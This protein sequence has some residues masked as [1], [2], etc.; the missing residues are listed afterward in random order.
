MNISDGTSQLSRSYYLN[1]DNF[2]HIDEMSFHEL[3]CYAKKLAKNIRYF[4]LDNQPEGNWDELLNSDEITVISEIIVVDTK[5]IETEFVEN[6][7]SDFGDPDEYL[8][9]QIDL[10]LKL[11]E[12]V[13]SWYVQ[14]S[15]IDAYYTGGLIKTIAELIREKLC[16][17][18]QD[19]RDLQEMLDNQNQNTNEVNKF[20]KFHKIW[21]LD[22]AEKSNEAG[23]RSLKKINIVLDKA[24]YT[25]YNSINYLKTIVPDYFE[26]SL[27]SQTHSP[28]LSLFFTFIKLYLKVRDRLNSFPEKFFRFYYNDI[29]KIKPRE[30]IPDS[31]YLVFTLKDGIKD[32]YIPKG[33]RFVGGKDETKKAIYY[34]SDNDIVINKARIAKLHTLYLEKNELIW[35]KCDCTNLFIDDI[36]VLDPDN[37]KGDSSKKWA[38]FGGSLNE[39]GK[40]G[41]LGFV[42]SD[43]N[44]LLTEGSRAI[45]LEIYFTQ[46]SFQLFSKKLNKIKD[47]YSV[48]EVF[49]KLF[50]NI[51]SISLTT[52]E[53][54]HLVDN[55]TID[56]SLI[57]ETLH[58]DSIKICFSLSVN[59]PAI[60]HYT[61]DI[62]GYDFDTINPTARFLI[63]NESYLFH[64]S[65]IRDLELTSIIT[66]VEV[67]DIKNIL[68]YNE[69]G[70]IDNTKPFYPFG[71]IPKINSSFIVGNYELAQKKITDLNFYIKW[72]D[73]PEDDNGL[74]EYYKEYNQDLKKSDYQCKISFLNNGNW[75]PEDKKSQQ[76]VNLFQPQCP[77]EKGPKEKLKDFTN[78]DRLNVSYFMQEE[79][80]VDISDYTFD[81]NS[82]GGFVRFSL[83]NPP[84]AFGHKEYPV[85]LTQITMHNAKSKVQKDLP[86]PPLSPLISCLSLGY[87]AESIIEFLGR[88]SNNK[89]LKKNF[90][91][92][93]PWG[94][95]DVLGDT[96]HITKNLIPTYNSQSNLFIGLKEA[97]PGMTVS[98]FFNLL[99]DS[100]LDIEKDPPRIRWEYLSNN[101]WKQLPAANLISDSTNSFLESGIVL[102]RIPKD[103]NNEN[104]VFNNHFYW[105]KVSTSDSL[106]A[107]CSVISIS[108]QAV[109]VTWENQ[110]NSLKHLEGPLPPLSIVKPESTL[111]GIKTI[112]Q[113]TKSFNGK[114]PETI[115]QTKIR[116]GERL[117]HKMRAVT[118]WDY[119]MLILEEFPEL[120]KVK[121][122]P[123]MSSD[124]YDNP[125]HVLITVIENVD[126][127]SFKI[128]YE[129]MLNNTTLHKIK[130]FVQKIATGFAKIEVRNPLF[131][132]VQVKCSV[133]FTAGLD[134]GY[135]IELL[136]KEIINYLTPWH[137]SGNNEPGFGKVMKCTD[138][139]SHIL[140]LDYVEYATEFSM[141][142]ISR[143]EEIKYD[144]FDTAVKER[145]VIDLNKG[146]D[147][148]E[149]QQENEE[150][151][152]LAPTFPWGILI[153]AEKHVI[154]IINEVDEIEAYKT[155]IDELEVGD[156]FII[157]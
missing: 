89:K 91:H 122:F 15:F 97:K 123:H 92:L 76:H 10:I 43:K 144:L 39:P 109:K 128:G 143:D 34:T 41:E 49:V 40:M 94:Y 54:W 155:G 150:I 36:P 59:D 16:L 134:A 96:Q 137:T 63:N 8:N 33:T 82:L 30:F 93:H 7:K 64:Y 26:E 110:G 126:E 100:V 113:E 124:K 130:S 29:L 157:K 149:N 129:P 103:I 79:R 31:S 67:K 45:D 136:N 146:A 127:E 42:I 18:L 132:R 13:D 112:L 80:K 4:N 58:P 56:C 105:I 68:I 44:L 50:S 156:T 21:W 102:L 69:L 133:K 106:E 98:I 116:I 107:I 140:S 9:R 37:Y 117:K 66:K 118:P 62:H 85:C 104:T 3:V 81:N 17:K 14:L 71:V 154:E 72:S 70:R 23:F 2:V 86:N 6:L 131:E 99:D 125:G 151:K 24:F 142:Q 77:D 108:T 84:F 135:F 119:E 115:S 152:I 147:D 47:E 32:F 57:E 88:Q 121:C 11:A 87:K 114:P 38:L 19:C 27:K 55:Y 12:F 139:L 48:N 78:W 145:N 53:G 83:C 111:A 95:E 75:L 90:Y 60:T 153:S 141:I 138:V 73:L 52:E 28:Y 20:H 1:D 61:K 101:R 148:V 22:S 5:E 46:E 35:P 65:L 25:F 51:F 120:Y 74:Q